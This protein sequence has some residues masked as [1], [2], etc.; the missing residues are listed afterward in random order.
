MKLF[1]GNLPAHGTPEDL[2]KLLKPF[3]YRKG[4]EFNAWQDCEGDM[5][6]YAVLDDEPERV[7][8][9]IIRDLGNSRLLDSPLE[10]REFYQRHSYQNERREL[11]WRDQEWQGE[12]RRVRE[13]RQGSVRLFGDEE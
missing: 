12:E 9:K 2:S 6:Y 13:R 8:R 7:A 10:I 11:G 3:G 4:I 5:N 1:I